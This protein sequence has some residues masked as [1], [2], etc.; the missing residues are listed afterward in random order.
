LPG[1][2]AAAGMARSATSRTRPAAE[3]A[4]WSIP[5]SPPCQVRALSGPPHKARG[6]RS[7]G[8][9]HGDA[10]ARGSGAVSPFPTGPQ[11]C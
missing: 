7:A 6:V 5:A 11:G 8:K 10:R 1:G 4:R 9:G 2:N 3:R